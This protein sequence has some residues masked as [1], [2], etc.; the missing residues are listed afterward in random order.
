MTS[1]EPSDPA[2]AQTLSRGIAILELLAERGE[3]ASIPEI[4]A[5]LGLHRSIAYRLLRTLE[6]HRLVVRDERGLVTLGPRL[7]SLAAGVDRDLQSAALP[8]LRA[9]AEAL[10]AT[11]FLVVLDHEEAVTL[12]SVEPRRSLVTVAED[13]GTLHP[14]GIGAPGRAVLAQLPPARWPADLTA[15]QREATARVGALGYASS[16]GEVHPGLRGV[17]V[18]LAI[19]GRPPLALAVVYVTSRHEEPALADRLRLAA[20][21]LRAA[22]G[23]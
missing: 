22:L 17:A 2:L 3:P 11:C 13:P 9:T 23:H 14:L 10:G 21:E 19:E 16:D 1:R 20:D 18:P 12:V 5:G 4:V 15:A 7:A 6:H 8:V